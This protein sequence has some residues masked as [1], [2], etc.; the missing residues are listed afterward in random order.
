MKA[1]RF[2]TAHRAGWKRLNELVEQAQRR[3]LSSLSDEELHELGSLY[4]RTSS[5]LARAQTRLGGT[6]AG[7]DLVRSLNDLVLRSHTQVYS[8]PRA[9]PVRI[10][11]FVVYGFPAAV[12]RQWRAIMLAAVL[13]A[14]PALVS[15]GVVITNPHLATL[16]IRPEVIAQ[17]HTRA[18]KHQLTG[19][20]GNT[21]YQGP[22][23]SP[24]ISSLIMSHNI[25][26]TIYSVAL[27]VTMGL[28]TAYM[29]VL[30]GLMLGSL[31][32][33]A[34][35]DK[36]NMLFWAVI[37]P[38][39]IIELT[40]VCLAGGAGFLLARALYAPG[41]VPRR[42]AMRLA[43]LE[44]ARLMLGVCLLLVVAGT[45]E[46]CVTPLPLDPRLKLAFAAV[47]AAALLLYFNA[48]PARPAES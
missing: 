38:H 45:I 4:R 42:D 33:V 41:D 36:I 47:T 28:G 40:S 3:R 35:N 43:G 18:A 5:D 8:A 30:N 29:L 24:E 10:F 26:V 7:R 2:V 9:Q 13:M 11:N 25:R 14:T 1:E 48:R 6:Q 46:G 20:G 16:F 15:Y 32:A 37:L 27:G 23:A 21:D 34:T 31:S 44:A 39:G 22:L 17:V 12:R 19:W